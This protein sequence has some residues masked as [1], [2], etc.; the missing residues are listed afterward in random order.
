MRCSHCGTLIEGAQGT[1]PLCGAPVTPQAPVHPPRRDHAKR[2]IVPFTNVYL[3]VALALT[4]VFATLNGVFAPEVHYW[5]LAIVGLWYIY[6]TL[7]H[8][9]LATENVY[10]KMWTQSIALLILAGVCGWVLDIDVMFVWVL[11]AVYGALWLA[12]VIVTAVRPGISKQYVI[13]IW[14]Q[15][16]L[17]IVMPVLCWVRH[18]PFVFAVVMAGLQLLTVV[19]VTIIHPKEIANQLARQFDK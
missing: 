14:G 13:A 3:F 9:I 12:T 17:G 2:Y 19:V 18:L 11:P 7:R 6:F 4:A 5:L 8:S 16:M 15:G 10:Y 1:C